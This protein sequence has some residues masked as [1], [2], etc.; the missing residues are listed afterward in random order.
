MLKAAVIGLG[1]WGK[2]IVRR[3]KGSRD[4][5]L[6]LAVD[7]NTTL[8]SFA[9]EHGVPYVASFE[10]ALASKDVEAV[11]LATPH[12]MHTAQIAAAAKAGKHVFCEKPLALTRKDA[13]ASVEA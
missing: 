5:K 3:I 6:V 7:Q 1:W 11:I 10:A 4:L 13:E 9:K 2:H 8:E 12:S